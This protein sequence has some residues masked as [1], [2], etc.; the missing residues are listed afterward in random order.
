MAFDK[1]A[2]SAWAQMNWTR[3]FQQLADLLCVRNGSSDL[4]CDLVRAH[5]S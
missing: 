3:Y 4:E 1:I 5:S 2:S